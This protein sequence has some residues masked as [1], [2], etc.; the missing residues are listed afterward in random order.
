[1]RL[2][3][4]ILA[5]ILIF[6]TTKFALAYQF[7]NQ[8][9]EI[10]NNPHNASQCIP[11]STKRFS[12]SNSMEKEY[13][14]Y[15]CRLSPDIKSFA[16]YYDIDNEKVANQIL[17]PIGFESLQR[18]SPKYCNEKKNND[19]IMQSCNV[20]ISSGLSGMNGEELIF[21]SPWTLVANP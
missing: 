14:Y 20:F 8:I 6:I 18:A 15:T 10:I 13:L 5:V 9:K 2:L 12:Y 4:I 21:S 7:N 11:I 17:L 16:F 19:V 3:K 1:M